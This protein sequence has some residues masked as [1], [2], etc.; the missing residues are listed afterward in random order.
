MT[1][2][3]GVAAA[4]A[5]LLCA[6][7][8]GFGQDTFGQRD[9]TSVEAV[10]SLNAYAAYKLGNYEN[11]REAWLAL[12]DRGNTSAMINLANMYEQGQ[13]IPADKGVARTWMEKAAALGDSRAQL[14]LGEDYEAG[15]GVERNPREAAAWFRKAAEQGDATAQFNLGVMLATAYGE[16]LA[17]SPPDQRAEAAAWLEKAADGGHPDAAGFLA[18]LKADR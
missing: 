5:L 10:E 4:T 13:G 7:A 14:H 6:A 3:P 12:A 9:A 8:T 15:H 17:H 11:A 1:R 18:S 2:A 16:G